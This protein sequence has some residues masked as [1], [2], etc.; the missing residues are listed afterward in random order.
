[1]HASWTRTRCGPL[2][3]DLF[4]VRRYATAAG[5]SDTASR[6]HIIQVVKYVQ[7][8]NAV[9]QT[10]R[11]TSILRDTKLTRVCNVLFR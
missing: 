7:I 1:M 10:V 9:R 2:A 5:T 8:D 4:L 11:L 3:G 6:L